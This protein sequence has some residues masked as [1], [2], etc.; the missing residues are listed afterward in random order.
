M[1]SQGLNALNE[2]LLETLNDSGKVYLTH[3]KLN[4]VY[5]IRFVVGQTNQQRRHVREAWELIQLT[6]RAMTMD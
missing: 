4:G 6:A 3:T 1:D 5:C 2:R